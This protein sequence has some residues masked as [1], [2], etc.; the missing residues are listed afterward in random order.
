MRGIIAGVVP[1]CNQNL[2]NAL[3]RQGIRR[4]FRQEKTL[5]ICPTGYKIEIIEHLGKVKSQQKKGKR[6][7]TLQQMKYFVAAADCGSISEAAKRLYAAQS[8]VSSAIKEVENHYRIIAFHRDSKG[9]F[10]TTE[11]KE[12]VLEFKSILDRMEFLDERYSGK[13]YSR[14]GFSV[15]VQH[16][17]CGMDSFLRILKD[18]K[19]D[20]YWFGFH[21]CKTVEVLDRLEK[22][23]DDLGIIF[24]TETRKSQMIQ[25][26]RNRGLIFNHIAYKKAHVY[27]SAFHPLAKKKE[28]STQELVKY[29][30]IT[31]DRRS[32]A[33]TSYTEMILPHVKITKL[34]S[35]SDRAAAYSLLR[36]CQGFVLGSGYETKDSGYQDIVAIPMKQGETIEIGWLVK[37]NFQ[38]TRLAQQFTEYLLEE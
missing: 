37:Q 19:L 9:V 33:N 38:L 7:M 34:I 11:G 36:N 17:I 2:F 3:K 26:L 27:V 15:C 20:S 22:G 30:F 6:P 29:P 13:H 23:L 14:D 1:F 24:F 12:L 10:L 4:Q 28:I 18:V 32:D 5:K 21:E 35:V 16:H 25:E 31:Y 8:S